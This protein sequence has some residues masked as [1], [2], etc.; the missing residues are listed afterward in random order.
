[1][2]RR[3]FDFIIL[4]LIGGRIFRRSYNQLEPIYDV[5]ADPTIPEIRGNTVD[6]GSELFRKV[7]SSY[8]K[9]R[10]NITKGFKGDKVEIDS[11]IYIRLVLMRSGGYHLGIFGNEVQYTHFPLD[12]EWTLRNSVMTQFHLKNK[13]PIIDSIE[14]T[15]YMLS[16]EDIA[17][18]NS[19]ARLPD[20]RVEKVPRGNKLQVSY[21]VAGVGIVD[22]FDNA[23]ILK[24]YAQLAKMVQQDSGFGK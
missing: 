9:L 16:P 10:P 8:Q 6:G 7:L 18:K 23:S 5:E 20:F 3:D 12:E 15:Y 22:F 1:M 11:D 17:D 2:E 19:D 24:Q 21:Y 13:N 14:E 4:S